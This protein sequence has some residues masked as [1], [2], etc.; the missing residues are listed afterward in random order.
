LFIFLF[1]SFSPNEQR[2]TNCDPDAQPFYGYTFLYPEIVNK[3]AAYAPFFMRWDHYYQQVYFSKDI[4]KEENIEE[5]VGRFCGQPEAADVEEVVYN[6]DVQD[7]I[8]LHYATEDKEKKTLLPPLLSGNTFAEMIALN[9]CT[10]VIEYLMYAKKCEPY[11]VP[12]G[13]AWTPPAHDEETMYELITE[14]QGRFK[15]TK[16]HF[17]KLRYAYQ[18]I[19]L[20]HYARDWN[21]TLELYN[22]LIPQIDLRKK[23]IIFFWITGHVAG[24]MQKLGRYPEA[25]YRYSL[26]F[27]HCPSKRIQAWRSFFIRN[28]KEWKQTLDLCQSDAERATLYAMRAGGSHLHSVEDMQEIYDL[29]PAN[30]QLDL[31]LVGMVQ[32]LE[33]IMLRTSVTDQK[34]GPA[35]GDLKRQNAEKHVLYLQ[36]FVRQV[37]QEKKIPSQKLWQAMEGYL[38][39]LAGDRVAAYKDWEQLD[40]K[41]DD[42]DDDKNLARQLS[43]WHCLLDVMNLDT[44]HPNKVDSVAYAVRSEN[45]FKEYPYFE[46]F[47]QDW[48]SQDY[49]KNAHPGKAILAAWSSNAL[50]YNPSLAVLDD[51]LR[52]ADSNDP[53]LLE[54]TMMTDTNPDFI[55]TQLLEIR[56]AYLLSL[57]QP[58][59]ALATL[60][61]IKPSAEIRLSKFSPFRE[62][63]GEKIHRDLVYD[64]IFLNRRQIAEKIIEFQTKAKVAE[65]ENDSATAARYN[66]LLG[67]GYYNMSYFGYEWEVTDLYRSGYNQLR[68]A[69]GPVFPLKNSPDGNRENTDV[70]LALSYFERALQI[71]NDRETAARATYMAAR[72]RQKQWFCDPECTYRPGSKLIPTLPDHYMDYYNEL[73]TKY[74]D[75]KFYAAVVKQCKWLEAYAR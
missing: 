57:G 1:A 45:I 11:V 55:E 71:A 74:S 30:P 7:L 49:V 14:G 3:N 29:D 58:E 22:L 12:T 4:Q 33:K 63:T 54:K 53:V 13:D 34:Y 26:V 17:I 61:K 32:E 9:G 41:L 16:S 24:A 21:Y 46:P 73:T 8:H 6:T 42:D 37:V 38:E 56:G 5:W 47:L 28:D 75:T 64:T 51:L 69:Q 48:L 52:L 10:E 31:L 19:R 67:L 60:R 20:A 66:Y 44:I 40:K 2:T 50:K 70:S 35:I 39:L 18:I 65:V 72:C 15:E 62:K 43:I 23:S 59:A 36:K 68:L 25:A 27:R